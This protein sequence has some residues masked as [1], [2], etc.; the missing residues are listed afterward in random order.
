MLTFFHMC[1]FPFNPSTRI[2]ISRSLLR[3]FFLSPLSIGSH[4]FCPT[5][6]QS[7]AL[8]HH[9]TSSHGIRTTSICVFVCVYCTYITHPHIQ[10]LEHLLRISINN[11]I[12]IN[13]IIIITSVWLFNNLPC[14]LN[15]IDFRTENTYTYD[16]YR[17]IISYYH[18]TVCF[19]RQIRRYSSGCFR[20]E[21]IVLLLFIGRI[22]D[23]FVFFLFLICPFIPFF[24]SSV[25]K[26]KFILRF[27]VFSRFIVRAFPEQDRRYMCPK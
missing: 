14:S 16:P 4:A 21:G 8:T 15:L 1:F 23:N 10:K 19:A 25:T 9:P 13:D 6:Q 24:L 17:C 22:A 20:I 2:P 18:H 7:N 27:L 3:V 5:A 26:Y 12:I 11:N